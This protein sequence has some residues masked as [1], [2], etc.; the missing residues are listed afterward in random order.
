MEVMED[1]INPEASLLQEPDDRKMQELVLYISW[2]CESDPTF[3][4]AKLN[5]ILFLSDFR[6]YVHLG[7]SI[8]GQ[9]YRAL[10][11][12]PAPEH[13]VALRD[14]PVTLPLYHLSRS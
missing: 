7:R 4:A 5:K 6:A 11:Q 1:V 14:V 10:E 8:T 9:E 13:L 2:M 3:G 12:G